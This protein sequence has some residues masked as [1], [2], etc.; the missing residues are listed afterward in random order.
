[1]YEL[2]YNTQWFAEHNYGPATC[3]SV[4]IALQVY[5]IL[6]FLLNL[7]LLLNSNIHF[8]CFPISTHP[9]PALG[10]KG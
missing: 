1:M 3:H 4:Y 9:P 6:R 10:A 2:S 8:S 5:N 7:N